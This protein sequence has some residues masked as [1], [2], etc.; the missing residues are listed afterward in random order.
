MDADTEEARRIGRRLWQIRKDRGKSLRVIGGLAGLSASSLSRIENGLRP[1]DSRSEVVALANALGVAPSELTR[2]PEPTPGNGEGAAVKAVRR[3]LIAVSRDD[4]V[5]H[6]V[7]VDVLRTRVAAVVA[8]KGNCDHEQVGR[9]LPELIRDL[10]TSIAAGRNVAEL[11]V[12]AVMLHVQGTHGWLSHMGASMDLGW[13][14]AVLARQAAHEHGGS[15]VLGVAAF[16]AANGLLAAGEFDTAQAELDSVIVSTTSRGAEQ[17]AGM[18]ALSRSLIAAADNRVGDVDA[19]LSYA[20]ELAART[21]EGNAYA[22]GFG[23][24]N[25]G[26]WRMSIL[27]EKHH[28]AHAVSVAE[29]LRPELLRVTTRQAAYWA[30]YGRALARI[31]GRQDDAVRALR[32][33]E[34]ISPARVQRH[35]FTRDALAELLVRSRRGPVGRELRAMA[36]RAGLPVQRHRDVD[37]DA[38]VIH[39]GIQ[40]NVAAQQHPAVPVR[41]HSAPSITGRPTIGDRP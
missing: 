35:P 26:V 8:A 30:D 39:I 7:P 40:E 32:K 17:L 31:R 11:L 2:V 14:A 25:I 9:E 28:Y 22:M 24:T 1:L 3:A 21:G 12:V 16:G 19:P 15:E 37:S 18:L 33:A 34:L 5:G 29:G 38:Q 13:Q 36:Y 41:P 27:L 10:H 23:P 6:V 4:P 20:A